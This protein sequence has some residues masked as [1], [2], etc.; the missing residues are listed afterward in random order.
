MSKKGLPKDFKLRHDIHYVEQLASRAQGSAIGRTVAIEK[1][2]PNPQQPRTELGDLSELVLSIREQG[3][4]EPLLVRRSDVGRFM[5]IAGERRYRASIE[6]GLKEVPCIELDVD[7][8]AVAEISLIENLQRKDLTPFEEADGL[9][10]LVDRFGYTHEQ[11]SKRIGKSRTSITESLSIGS[12]P[13]DLREECRRADISSKSM[14]L[15]VVRQPS[16]D[17]MKAFVH[18]IHATG[19]T[20]D[21][22]R[23]SRSDKGQRPRPYTFRFNAKNQSYSVEVRF[24]KAHASP[25]DIETALREAISSLRNRKPR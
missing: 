15:Q 25:D 3:V 5:I 2:V 21:E 23:V 24:R 17:D 6:A 4:L 14:L 20:R 11:I 22:A 9:R 1:L 16:V 18:K 12:I 13:A 7:D 19:M 10:S 8:R